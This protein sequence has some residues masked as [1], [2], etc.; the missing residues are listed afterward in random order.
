MQNLAESKLKNSAK[1]Y[2][3]GFETASKMSEK[4]SGLFIFKIKNKYKFQNKRQNARDSKIAFIAKNTE[5]NPASEAAKSAND[6][7]SKNKKSWYKKLDA[8]NRKNSA[9][10]TSLDIFVFLKLNSIY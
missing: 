1:L 3:S 8:L 7:I 2:F 5:T 6:K 10:F 9:L 4:S